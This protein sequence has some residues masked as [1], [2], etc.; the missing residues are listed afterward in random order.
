M[1]APEIGSTA[2]DPDEA[3]Q[4]TAKVWSTG[5]YAGLSE[6]LRP[7]AQALADA[8]AV[9][10]GQ[11]VLDVAA[12]DGNFAV[13]CAAEGCAVVASD[14]APG[15]VEKGRARSDA[16]GYDIEWVEAN[17]QELPFD[18]DRF[19]CVGLGVRG[20]D[21]AGARAGGAGA[22]PRRAARQHRGHD[23]LD[24]RAAGRRRCSTSAAA[25]RP[26]ARPSTRPTAGATRT[27]CAAGSTAWP[28][29][30]SSSAAAWCGRATRPSSS[31]R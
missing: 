26:A 21:R 7:A 24:A 10:A 5:D 22:V 19:E 27:T 17:A 23:G 4:Q 14:L 13:A 8:C 9:G 12:G 31:W 18:D 3:A 2:V 20:D 16:E 1:A 15:M 6:R 28:T 11:E 25:T 30:S 29:R